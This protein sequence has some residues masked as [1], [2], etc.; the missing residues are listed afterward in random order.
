MIDLY[1][2]TTTNGYRAR[3]ILEEL[4]LPYRLHPVNLPKHENRT[5][6]FLALS[7]GHKIP[8]IVDSDGPGGRPIT[9]AESG[10]IL[11]YLA[12]KTG[13]ALVPKDPRTRVEMEEW[14][15]YGISTFAMNLTQLGL[16]MNRFPEDLPSVKKHYDSE[17]RDMYGVIDQRLR[18]RDY[19]AGELSLADFAHYTYVRNHGPHKISLDDYPNVKRWYGAMTARPSVARAY[20]P[21]A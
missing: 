1:F 8:V 7:I 12:E 17:A 19:F 6:Q 13:S 21:I 14:F 4:G 11:R 15:S 10:A 18:G 3:L 16:F 20:A 5:P 9:L 2:W